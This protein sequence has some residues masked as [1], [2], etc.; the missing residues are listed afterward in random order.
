MAVVVSLMTFGCAGGGRKNGSDKSPTEQG[1]R[2]LLL[3]LTWK[4][5]WPKSDSN[6]IAM[7]RNLVRLFCYSCA[8]STCRYE[9]LTALC[10]STD[11][12]VTPSSS[13]ALSRCC[14]C[15]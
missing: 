15:T 10:W 7:A 4:H 11:A 13:S 5:F 12:V 6:F 1:T 8:C 2:Y 9:Q 14:V 3:D